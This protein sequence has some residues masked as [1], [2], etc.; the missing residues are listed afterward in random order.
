MLPGL[1]TLTCLLKT[2]LVNQLLLSVIPQATVEAGE[3]A[4]QS[5][6]LVAVAEGP[7]SVPAPT[8]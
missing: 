1:C 6:S 3:M 4:Q 5:K 2:Q 7:G 8:W